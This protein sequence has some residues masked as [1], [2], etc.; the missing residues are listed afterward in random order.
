MPHHRNKPKG[1]HHQNKNKSGITKLIPPGKPT[2]TRLNDE[3]VMVRWVV[4]EH[5]GAAIRFFKVQYKDVGPF[6]GGRQRHKSK[7]EEWNTI[8][9][10]I[11]PHLTDYEVR[12]LNPDH[13]YR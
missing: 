8:S 4:P 6:K 3:S 13:L 2:I 10:S 11:E 7:S 1:K 12:D 9:A 5:P